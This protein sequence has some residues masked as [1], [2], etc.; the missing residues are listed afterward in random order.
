MAKLYHVTSTPTNLDSYEYELK[1]E[2]TAKANEKN[3]RIVGKG[4][5]ER[6]IADTLSKV[7]P[8][9][10]NVSKIGKN[11]DDLVKRGTVVDTLA[12]CFEG[13]RDT[14]RGLFAEMLEN[15][16]GI[17][18]KRAEW[19]RDTGI[20]R[21]APGLRRYFCTSCYNYHDARPNYCPN[22]GAYMKGKK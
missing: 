14:L 22:C 9:D 8:I 11:R 4:Y 12:D 15:I 16:P 3:D 7:A 1:K 20:A 5:A 17:K 2:W 10:V 6:Q 19:I 13:D 21:A 18:Q